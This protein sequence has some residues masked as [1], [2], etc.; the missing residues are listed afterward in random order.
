M[1]RD[2][3]DIVSVFVRNKLISAA[4]KKPFVSAPAGLSADG[5]QTISAILRSM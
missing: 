3:A 1:T 4:V 5:I 2:L